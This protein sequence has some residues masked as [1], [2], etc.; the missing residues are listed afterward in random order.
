MNDTITLA[1]MALLAVMLLVAAVIDV[2]TFTIANGLNLAIAALGLAYWWSIG[3][4]LWPDGAIRAGIA[5]AVFA[6]LAITFMIGMMGGGDVKLAAALALWFTPFETVRF[7]VYMSIAGGLL[8]LIVILAHRRWPNWQ[9]DDEGKP[10][11][12]AEV[13]YGVAIAAG[14]LIVLAQRFL[15]HF[16]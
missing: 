1:L 7:L 15:N 4:P 13:P 12:K 8:T 14:A 9:V 5:L 3:L 6:I 11:A 16:A 10:K 2:R